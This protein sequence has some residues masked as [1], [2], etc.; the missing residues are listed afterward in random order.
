MASLYFP[1]ILK[2]VVCQRE[3]FVFKGGFLV[4]AF[5]R[6]DPG[7][8]DNYRSLFVSS[9][10]AKAL[11]AV[12]RKT[13]VTTF[14]GNRLPLQLGGVPGFS[15]TQAAHILRLHQSVAHQTGKSFAVLFVDVSNAFYSLIRRHIVGSAADTR[16]AYAL[17]KDLHLPED[18][19]IEFEQLLALGPAIDASE[20]DVFTKAMFRQFYENTWF[21][22]RGSEMIVHSRRGSRPGDTFADVC[23][24]FAMAKILKPV[25]SRLQMS[26]PEIVVSGGGILGPGANNA[27]QHEL[28]IVAPIWADD[29]AVSFM[30]RQAIDL[31]QVAGEVAGA[32]F[33]ALFV[34]GLVPNLKKGKSELLVDIRGKHSVQVRKDLC[35]SNYEIPTASSFVQDKLRVVGDYKHL[36]T[37]MQRRQNHDKEFRTK[38]AQ[39]HNVLTRYKTQI[40]G[41]KLMQWSQFFESLAMSVISY[42]AAV[43]NLATARERQHFQKGLFKLYRRAAILH[44]GAQAMH[45]GQAKIFVELE[46]LRPEVLLTQARLRYLGHLAAKGQEL[47]WAMV[48]TEQV[49]W[50]L[51]QTDFE[52]LRSFCPT[53]PCPCPT[54]EWNDFAD[55]VCEAP[56]RWKSLIKRAVRRSQTLLSANTNGPNGTRPFSGVCKHAVW[57]QAATLA[58]YKENITVCNVDEFLTQPQHVQYTLSN[59][60]MD[61]RLSVNMSQE[62]FVSHVCES[63]H[64][65]PTC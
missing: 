56:M 51:I 34:A 11:H 31:L 27:I 28:G 42:N 59:S 3:A 17:F 49:W 57:C 4:P 39:A 38:F 55:Y 30:V 60:M 8:C 2:Q 1:L 45:W 63:T 7:S 58:E 20:V 41:N 15:I 29:L 36:G 22:M 23:F 18:A 54:R 19:W 33:D 65:I 53:E 47:F 52:W 12:Y 37:W 50:T 14:E 48:Q 64:V 62:L 9:P 13:L 10:I 44:F 43:W 40:F 6:G 61:P 35:A 32:I 46:L 16:N 26:R 25:F 5:K 24:G 21:Q